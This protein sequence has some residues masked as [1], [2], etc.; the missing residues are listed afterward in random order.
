MGEA[1]RFV[2]VK[3]APTL[4]ISRIAVSLMKAL[5]ASARGHEKLVEL[6][7]DGYRIKLKSPPIKRG[8]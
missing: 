3:R 7:S 4:G 8:I 1:W 2:Q 6:L 5:K